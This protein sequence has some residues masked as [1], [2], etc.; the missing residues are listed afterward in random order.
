[1]K[2]VFFRTPRPKQFAYPPRYYDA[3]KER[4]E[5]RKK[6]L[7]LSEEKTDFQSP[8]SNNWS[9]FRSTDRTRKKKAEISVLVYFFIVAILIYFLFFV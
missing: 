8:L 4:W 1:M 5:N 3:E 6:E 2:I 7:G 9:R